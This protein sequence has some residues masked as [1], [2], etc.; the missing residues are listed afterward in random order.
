MWKA[1]WRHGV[2]SPFVYQFIEDGLQ[3]IKMGSLKELIAI[4]FGEDTL[5]FADGDAGT[6]QQFMSAYTGT[7]KIIAVKNIHQTPQY[8]RQWQQLIND[9]QV[10]LSIDLFEYGLIFFNK[11]FKEKQHFILKYPA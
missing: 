3:K 11:E 1:K 9:K 4:Y 5:A 2:H 7:N 8:T 6:W 10:T